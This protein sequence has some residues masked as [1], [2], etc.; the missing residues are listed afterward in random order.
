[1]EQIVARKLN[2]TYATPEGE[3]KDVLVDV[4][5][6]VQR[7]EFIALL[8]PSGCEKT[9]LLNILAGL[10]DADSGEFS[11]RASASDKPVV[12]Y[13]FQESRLLP[14]M[15]VAENLAF[16]LDS[17]DRERKPRIR[18][19]LERVGLK[20]AGN[21]YPKQLSVGMQQR[22]AVARALIVDPD[23]LFMDEPFSSL[24]ELT[25]MTMRQELLELW[26]EQGCT[27]MLVT[28]NPL[29]AV[30]LADRVIVM[31]PSPGR[32]AGTMELSDRLP[33]PRDPDDAALWQ[34]SRDAVSKLRKGRREDMSSSAPEAD[35]L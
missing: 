16:V 22:V 17:P 29:E 14:W 31:T 25:A 13:M 28:H 20:D 19:W 12:S 27:V 30:L 3:R 32:I 7:G 8:G 24:D 9:T 21:Y 26:A 15:T 23:V 5:L 18:S 6:T 33:R 1:V 34:V 2:K 35:R 11:I 10:V 4:D